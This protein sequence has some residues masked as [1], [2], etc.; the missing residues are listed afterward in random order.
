MGIFAAVEIDNI[1]GNNIILSR[2]DHSDFGDK[3]TISSNRFKEA[4]NPRTG[5]IAEIKSIDIKNNF[6]HSFQI[7]KGVNSFCKGDIV[8]FLE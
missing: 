4:K 5:I 6:A 3:S 8:T 7:D 1:E 2:R